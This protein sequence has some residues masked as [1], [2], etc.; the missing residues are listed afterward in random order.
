M[1]YG[2]C[3]TLYTCIAIFRLKRVEMYYFKPQG[4]DISD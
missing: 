1:V 3:D 4:Y 2:F